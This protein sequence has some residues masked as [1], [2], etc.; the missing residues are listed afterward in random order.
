MMISLKTDRYFWQSGFLFFSVVIF[1]NH[2]HTKT[3][4]H[5]GLQTII[6]LSSLFCITFLIAVA[7]T[8][9]CSTHIVVL[10]EIDLCIEQQHNLSH[11]LDTLK[12]LIADATDLATN[13][14]DWFGDFLNSLRGLV[15]WM[16]ETTLILYDSITSI[17]VTLVQYAAQLLDTIKK[18]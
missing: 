16:A 4:S 2:I 3:V 6:M 1:V 10:N 13:I 9:L 14:V 7:I 15:L 17:T 8:T 11:M 18:P 5:S 12:N